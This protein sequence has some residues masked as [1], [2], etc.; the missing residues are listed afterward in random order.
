QGPLV[1]DLWIEDGMIRVQCS[2]AD[3]VIALGSRAA[4]K[5]VYGNGMMQAELPLAVFKDGGW[6]RVVVA[7]RFDRKAWSN[8]IWLD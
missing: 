2:P 3:R 4:A 1:H 6:V 5:Q 8:P 7:D